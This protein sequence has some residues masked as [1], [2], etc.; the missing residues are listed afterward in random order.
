MTRTEVQVDLQLPLTSHETSENNANVRCSIQTMAED[1]SRFS[2]LLKRLLSLLS[3]VSTPLPPLP[4]APPLLLLNLP[5]HSQQQQAAATD[6]FTATIAAKGATTKGATTNLDY[7]ISF[8]AVSLNMC[9][10][11]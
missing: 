3:L 6:V 4:L 11:H 2:A 8:I 1:R 7:A 10:Q 9:V 5:R